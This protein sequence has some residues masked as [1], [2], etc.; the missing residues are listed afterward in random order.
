[1][2][3][4]AALMPGKVGVNARVVCRL[5]KELKVQLSECFGLAWHI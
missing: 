2:M 5:E 3:R 1:M 4:Y